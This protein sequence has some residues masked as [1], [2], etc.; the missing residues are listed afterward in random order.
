MGLAFAL[1]VGH[2]AIRA[3][4]WRQ[5]SYTGEDPKNWRDE[6][7]L[8]RRAHWRKIVGFEHFP[9][10]Q[11]GV[12]WKGG[13]PSWL[14]GAIERSF[15]AVLVGFAGPGVAAAPMM[16][17]LALKTA[18]NWKRHESPYLREMRHII[19]ASQV[20]TVA[21]LLSLFFALVGGLIIKIL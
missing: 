13:A 16:I 1:V 18:I 4:L 17:W 10:P 8:W 15:F 20:S 9:P 14:M 11:V 6:I 21:S 2:L 19:R 3:L 7:E 12:A 5:W